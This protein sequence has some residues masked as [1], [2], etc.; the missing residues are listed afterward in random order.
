[1]IFFHSRAMGVYQKLSE[2][3]KSVIRALRK[4]N[5]SLN[6]ILE[7]D[8][9][10]Q[11]KKTTVAKFL[12]KLRDTGSCERKPGSGRPKTVRTAENIAAV[13]ERILSQEDRPGTSQ[14][15]REVEKETG[16]SRSS[17]RR[18]IKR[19]LNLKVFKRVR[20]QELKQE[21][22][23]KRKIRCKELLDHF[24][25]N[26]DVEDIFFTDE[27]LFT[28][29]SPKNSQN[30]R[31]HAATQKKVHIAANRLLREAQ[32]FTQSVMVSLGASSRH[33]TSVIFVER[34]AKINASYY[35]R[36]IL[37]PM[38]A[39]IQELNPNFVFQ[40][41]GAPA[42][43]AKT[44]VAFLTETC[45]ENFIKP[46][47]WPPSSPDLNPIDYFVWAALQEKVY[48]GEKVRDVEDLKQRILLA[49]EELPQES[50][51]RAIKTW[52]D[53]LRAVR[54]NGGGHAEHL[55]QH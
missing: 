22:Q 44:T 32:H 5:F 27:K 42:H 36:E 55:F 4:K 7:F 34:G 23:Q 51:T 2:D 53:R 52:R 39:E 16:I 30:D 50:I 45:D 1:M 18:I 31:V 28:V 21:A 19:D 12:R 10:R 46:N 41:D 35:Q 38:L 49:W 9:E 29:R 40:Q 3:D 48:R 47:Q 26:E 33:K 54:R 13:E 14:S 6:K 8:P 20:V 15:E 24:L 25:T 17:V 11:W 43:T 37:S